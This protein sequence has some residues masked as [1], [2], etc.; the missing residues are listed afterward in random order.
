MSEPVLVIH[1]IPKDDPV[2][3]YYAS[4]KFVSMDEYIIQDTADMVR[5]VV[6]V[7]TQNKKRVSLLTITGHGTPNGFYVGKDWV[8]KTELASPSSTIAKELMKLHAVLDPNGMVVIRACDVGESPE[9]LQA[10]SK[11]LGGLAVRGSE[12]KQLG[13]VPGLIGETIE[14]KL[15]TCKSLT[16]PSKPRTAEQNLPARWK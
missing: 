1:V 8:T 7:S 2:N 4:S 16:L 15:T 13:P 10:V 3:L 11:T 14:C 12:W 9:L 5:Q 6:N